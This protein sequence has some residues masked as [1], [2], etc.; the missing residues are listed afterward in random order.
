MT[1]YEM[2]KVEPPSEY[3]PEQ[4]RYLRGNDF[5]PVAVIAIL[6]TDDSK[7]P[8][9]LSE[10]ITAAVEAGAAL[11]GTSREKRGTDAEIEKDLLLREPRRR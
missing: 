8:S 6:D 1:G 5:S 10:L 4:G 11:A 2:L 3:P 9:E 7:I